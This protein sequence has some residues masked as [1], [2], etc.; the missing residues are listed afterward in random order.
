MSAP[1]PPPAS[2]P[3]SPFA[4]GARA[5]VTE[6]LGE[7]FDLAFEEGTNWFRYASGEQAWRLWVDHY[8]PMKALAGSLDD[9]RR[10]ELQRAI[11]EWHETFASDLGYAQPRTY[12]ITRAVRRAV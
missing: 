6:L 10:T 12:L 9:A 3:P 1:V 7:R 4:W 11:V 2:P 8:G 5:R